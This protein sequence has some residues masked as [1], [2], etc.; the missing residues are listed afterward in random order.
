MARDLET[1]PEGAY[2]IQVD[3][4]RQATG[5]VQWTRYFG[6]YAT[7][8]TAKAQRARRAADYRGN[9]DPSVRAT[10]LTLQGEWVEVA[11]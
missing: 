9:P 6:V 7:A 8:A 5:E 2:L 11:L 10:I 3:H 4:L 1:K